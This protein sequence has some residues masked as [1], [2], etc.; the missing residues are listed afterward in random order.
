MWNAIGSHMGVR[1]VRHWWR[2][3]I[4]WIWRWTLVGIGRPLIRCTRISGWRW[5]LRHHLFRINAWRRSSG[6]RCRCACLGA[7]CT[8]LFH[9][10]ERDSISSN[11][12]WV[13]HLTFGSHLLSWGWVWN[14]TNWS[15]SVR[16]AVP[17]WCHYCLASPGARHS[18]FPDRAPP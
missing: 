16:A 8:R 6:V 1:I 13:R 3:S 12:F 18:S 7:R 15:R 17:A 9:L 14:V 5:S 11:T 2:S 10:N 4:G